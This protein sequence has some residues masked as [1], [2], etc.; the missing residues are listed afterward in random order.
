MFRLHQWLGLGL[1]LYFLVI[2]LSG[3]AIVFRPWLHRR[4]RGA[5]ADSPAALL[6]ECIEWLTRLHDELFLGRLG[7]TLNGVGGA[8]LILMVLSGL[9]L[10][11]KGSKQW[12]RSLLINSSNRVGLLRQLHAVIG[13]WSMLMLLVWGLTA[14]YFAWPGPVEDFIDFLDTD[15]QDAHRP[16]GW[17]LL[18]V[19]LHFGRFRG[20]VWAS[21]LWVVLGLLPAVLTIT[22]LWMWYRRV[23]R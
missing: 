13:V 23:L 19:D 12:Y 9:L 18:L 16:D 21:F 4:L 2:S 20:V 15:L 8:L 10:W 17:L 14:V 7:R 22:G 3:S 11:W 5:E 6:L 1:G